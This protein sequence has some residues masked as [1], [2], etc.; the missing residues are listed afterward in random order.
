MKDFFLNVVAK[1]VGRPMHLALAS[2]AGAGVSYRVSAAAPNVIE[3]W[4]TGYDIRG[5]LVL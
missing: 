3:Y 1:Q 5:R 4:V 2:L